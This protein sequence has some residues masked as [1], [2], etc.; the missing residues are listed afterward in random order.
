MLR[1]ALACWLLTGAALRAAAQWPAH[2]TVYERT[3]R[4]RWLNEH[5]QPAFTPWAAHKSVIHLDS[6]QANA[7]GVT[8]FMATGDPRQTNRTRARVAF[9]SAGRVVSLGGSFD[10]VPRRPGVRLTEDPNQSERFRT[11]LGGVTTLPV[12]IAWDL[13]PAM[14]PARLAAGE[15]WTD[16]VSW[17]QG[18]VGESQALHGVRTSDLVR[19]SV[20]EGRRYWLVRDT[21]RGTWTEQV[22]E[23]ERTLFADVIT[24]RVAH[25][26]VI[27]QYLV[28]AATRTLRSRDD[29]LEFTGTAT[30]RLPDGRTF[31]APT[32]FQQA[33][34]LEGF[35]STAYAALVIARRAAAPRFSMFRFP[36]GSAEEALAAGNAAVRDSLLRLFH[37]SRDVD[38]RAALTATLS[39]W[40]PKNKNYRAYRDTVEAGILRDGDT[41]STVKLLLDPAMTRLT[42]TRLRLVLPFLRDPGR[43]FA[44]GIPAGQFFENVE[45]RLGEISPALTPD[46]TAWPCTP[47][48]CTMLA[49]LRTTEKEPRLRKLG[50]AAAFSLDPRRWVD[51]VRAD[52]TFTLVR[53]R[54]DGV[55][56]TWIASTHPP[57]P[58]ADADWL[59][60]VAWMN[61]KPFTA[62]SA[63]RTPDAPPALRYSDTHQ[64]AVAM[65]ELLTRRDL[66]SEWQGHL[67]RATNGSERYVFETLLSHR[68]AW[69]PDPD[70]VATWLQTDSKIDR[71]RG[72]LG[73]STVMASAHGLPDS[74]TI[75]ELIDRMLAHTVDGEAPW[76]SIATGR[77]PTPVGNLLD[78][79]TRRGAGLAAQTPQ[80]IYVKTPVVTEAMRAKWGSRVTWITDSTWALTKER[81]PAAEITIRG[82]A[83]VGA[84][85]SVGADVF[86]ARADDKGI[87]AGQG[88]N[89]YLLVLTKE[90]WKIVG[91]STW[92]V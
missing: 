49:H 39:Q 7:A 58:A 38:A 72:Q 30:L 53:Y 5:Q 25:G 73:A 48:A 26:T 6:L 85:A 61:G 79:A 51:S 55:G 32:T 29:T 20:I 45:Q 27:G 40:R 66:T 41:T 92:V 44:F 57:M 69:H 18:Y 78:N 9:D 83:R 88:G 65:I 12:A 60:W 47:E 21:L 1:L 24:S 14:H 56:A 31:T 71:A 42:E 52:S 64:R 2:G 16:S 15:R 70:S 67:A 68:D 84:F 74:A 86:S 36:T 89:S 80:T 22:S 76:P 77:G 81:Y 75:T 23:Y 37:Q 91:V 33:R 8:T 10:S 59:A 50:L 4:E 35:D 82:M 54:I 46:T 11:G 34:H 90:G 63:A 19:D 28:D 3:V 87:N 43:A 62:D 13:I 17:S